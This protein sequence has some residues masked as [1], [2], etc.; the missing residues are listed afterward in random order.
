MPSKK[1][2]PRISSLI[3]LTMGLLI[4]LMPALPALGEPPLPPRRPVEL[5]GKPEPTE[6]AEPTQSA[7]KEK[8]TDKEK[9]KDKEDECSDDFDTAQQACTTQNMSAGM[10]PQQQQQAQQMQQ[11]AQQ[12]NQNVAGAG[13]NQGAQCQNQAD[14]S[15]LL[16]GLSALKGT[17]CMTAVSSCKDSCQTEADKYEAKGNSTKE[18]KARK[19]LKMCEGFAPNAGAAFAQAGAALAGMFANLACQKQSA[20][21]VATPVP[22]ANC[23]DPNFAKTNIMCICQN[24]PKS[25]MCTQGAAFPGGVQTTNGPIGPGTPA[26]GGSDVPSDGSPVTGPMGAGKSASGSSTTGEGGGAGPQGGKGGGG[27]NAMD[28]GGPGRSGFDKNVITGTAGGGGAAGAGGGAGGGGGGSAR[29]GGGRGV[30]S[31]GLFD[32]SK[33]LPK[34]KTRGVAGMSISAKDGITGPMGPS[35]W[36]KVTNQ[37]QLQKPNM[38]QDR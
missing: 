1:M 15:K 31:G 9:D 7:A 23:A 3:V 14:L 25:S 17:A 22:I 2:Q 20:T 28:D 8:D 34:S 4:S 35:I 30:G 29:G 12:A 33:F 21:A 37:Y 10:N 11:Q 16:A 5:G 32:L 38:F 27:L 19:R 26:Y 24:D 36:E 18:K 6:P 13:N